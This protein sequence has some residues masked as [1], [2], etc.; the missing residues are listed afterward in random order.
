M[1]TLE[2]DWT[3]LRA[4]EQDLEGYLLSP[5]LYLPLVADRGSSLEE[6][7]ERLTIGNVLLSRAR[8]LAF[9]WDEK[10]RIDL[11]KLTQRIDQ[12]RDRWCAAWQR[13]IAQEV[14][15]RLTLWRNCVIDAIEDRERFSG[16]EYQ[17]RWRVI[18]E[19]LDKELEVPLYESTRILAVLDSNLRTVTTRGTFI[20]Q[21]E[22]QAGFPEDPYWYLYVRMKKP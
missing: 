22:L 15:A 3:F 9:P 18:L 2:K 7:M 20:W 10:Q 17:V 14:P 4:A 21:P 16:Y 12:L 13:K 11:E 19:L 1:R 6:G 8:L 5:E